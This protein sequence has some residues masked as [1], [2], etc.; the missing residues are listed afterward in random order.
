MEREGK[1]EDG[2]GRRVENEEVER[3]GHYVIAL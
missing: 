2:E 1:G 3:K